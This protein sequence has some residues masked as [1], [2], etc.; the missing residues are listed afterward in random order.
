M[1]FT[2]L[3]RSSSSVPV[4]MGEKRGKRERR[5]LKKV[6]RDKKGKRTDITKETVF[7]KRTWV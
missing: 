7:E 3:F 4:L 1:H 2:T 6:S 5:M